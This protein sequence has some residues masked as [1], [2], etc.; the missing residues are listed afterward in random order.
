MHCAGLGYGI[1]A[2]STLVKIPQLL[3][4]YNAK[5]AEGL[6]PLSFE[7]ETVGLSVATTYGLLLSLPISAYGEVVALLLQNNLLLMM[8]YRYQRRSG[9]RT[10][11]LCIFMVVWTALASSGFMTRELISTLYDA[12]N[13]III[14]SRVPQILQNFAAKSTGQLSTITYGLNFLGCAARIFTS[15]HENAGA[16]MLRGAIISTLLNA[17]LFGQIVAYRGR[18]SKLGKSD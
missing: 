16:A 4:V 3:T 7:L 1:L 13:A 18:K 12:N 8:I 5:S 11:A 10:L 9:Q 15:V 6:S 14:L 2:G 17:V